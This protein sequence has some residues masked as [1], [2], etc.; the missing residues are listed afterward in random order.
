MKLQNKINLFT[1]IIL[2]LC[3]IPIVVAGY[4]AIS[5]I[6]YKLHHDLF[7]K[8]I[9]TINAKINLLHT[10]MEGDKEIEANPALTQAR[11]TLLAQYQDYRY[12]DTGHLYILNQTGHVILHPDYP[13]GERFDFD[14]V[15]NM[16][17]QRQG[18]IEYHYRNDRYF[19]VFLTTTHW[20]WLIVLSVAESEIFT[21][22]TAYLKFVAT[23]TIILF[24]LIMLFSDQFTRSLTQRVNLTLHLL[25]RI[26]T[27]NLKARIPLTRHDELG[28]IQRGINNMLDKVSDANTRLIQFKTTLDMALDGVF[29]FDEQDF[30]LFYVNQGAMQQVGYTEQA[31]YEKRIYELMPD[32]SPQTFQTLLSALLKSAQPA[33]TFETVCQHRDG[34]QLPVEIFLQYIQVSSQRNLFVAISRDITDRKLV[35]ETLRRAN[36]YNRSLIEASLDMLITIDADGQIRDVNSATETFTGYTREE[37]IGSDFLTYFTEPMKARAIYQ[38]VLKAGTVR[39]YELSIQHRNGT[40]TPVLYNAAAYHDEQGAIQ[41]IFAAAR[42]ITQ[43]KQ[44]EAELQRAKEAAETARQI[45][46]KANAAKSAFLANMSHELRTP[47]N[48]ILGYTQ[49]LARDKLLSAKQQEGVDIIQRSGDYLLNLINDILDLA[50]IEAERIELLPIDFYFDEFFQGITEL[51]RMRSQQKGV[52]F[53]FAPEGSLPVGLYA[54]EKRL[55][56]ILI[57]LLGNAVKFTEKGSVTLKV[58]YNQ[59]Q[60]YIAVSDTGVGVAPEEL[61]NIFLPFHQTG[62]REHRLQGT[63]LGLAITQKL[64]KMMGGELQVESTLGHGTCFWMTIN[65]PAA[66]SLADIKM[67]QQLPLIIGYQGDR[68]TILVIDDSWEN[69]SVLVNLLLSLGFNIVEAYDGQDGLQKV[70]YHRPD[71]IIT[72]LVMP[73]L[74][75]FTLIRDIKQSSALQHIPMIAASASVFEHHQQMSQEAGCEAFIPKPIQLDDLLACIKHLLQVQ[76]IYDKPTDL[77]LNQTGLPQEQTWVTPT[78]ETAQSLYDLAMRGDI[79]GILTQMDKL[80]AEDAQYIPFANKVRHLAKNFAEEQLCELAQSVMQK[81]TT[82]QSAEHTVE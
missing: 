4:L 66:T 39:D 71:L 6:V 46:E 75:G 59:E 26:E 51:F 20:D 77:T 17:A 82:I 81:T 42:D 21:S 11:Q 55:R 69:R 38:Q 60:L 22:R 79:G 27:G 33:L 52:D 14:Y 50:K 58:R 32:Y 16:L 74:D 10:S 64:V 73:T 68:K 76:W 62:K 44:S 56:Q 61:R 57:N 40:I 13:E 48:G 29:M 80:V 65:L 70:E 15:R 19:S 35:K 31:L 25:K 43:Q 41:G 3:G 12:G 49:L 37:L 9:Q 63:G 7:V 36:A 8:E 24:I 72:E 45:A 78:P 5:Q 2:A 23:F 1:F 30:L 47:L 54:D 34:T 18:V 53:I 28:V 67:M